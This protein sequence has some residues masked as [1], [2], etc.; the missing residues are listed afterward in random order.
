LLRRMSPFVRGLL[1]EAAAVDAWARRPV[2]SP[3]LHPIGEQ[4]PILGRSGCG[5]SKRSFWSSIVGSWLGTDRAR[6]VGGLITFLASAHC[7]P[8]LSSRALPTPRPFGRD[9]TSQL[10]SGWFLSKIRAE[11]RTSLATSA[12]EGIAICVPCSRPERSPSSAMPKSMGS[13]IGPGLWHCWQGD[14]LRL[15]LSHSPTSSRGSRGL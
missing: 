7:W 4:P 11:A 3:Y 15:R 1:Y 6:R 10:G 13:N 12:N 14:R 9:G 5:S 8:R 2:V